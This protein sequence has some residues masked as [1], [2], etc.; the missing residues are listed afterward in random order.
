MAQVLIGEVVE[1]SD[2]LV[3]MRTLI[4]GLRLVEWFYGEQLPRIC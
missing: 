4:G 1:D 2:N 3:Q